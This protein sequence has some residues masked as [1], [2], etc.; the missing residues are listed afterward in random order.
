MGYIEK[1]DSV[2][3]RGFTKIAV[4]TPGILETYTFDFTFCS[5]FGIILEENLELIALHHK[6]L[7]KLLLL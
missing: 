6:I 3:L 5:V 1:L 7:S 4:I 2:T